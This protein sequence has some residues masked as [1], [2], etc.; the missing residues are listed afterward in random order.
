MKYK[1][2]PF[3]VL[4]FLIPMW[5]ELEW[6]SVNEQKT[7]MLHESLDSTAQGGVASWYSEE[8]CKREGTSGIMANGKEF[9]TEC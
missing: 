4:L 8:S 7:N 5:L 9:N 1:L 2:I 6:C 3:C